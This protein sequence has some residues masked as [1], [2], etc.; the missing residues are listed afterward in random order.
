MMELS[1]ARERWK[2]SGTWPKVDPIWRALPC[3]MHTSNFRFICWAA[4]L[5]MCQNCWTN[6]RLGNCGISVGNND[7][8][9]QPREFHDEYI[10]QVWYKWPDSFIRTCGE[11]AIRLGSQK[12]GNLAESDLKS[13]SSMKGPINNSSII[14]EVNLLNSLSEDV[15]KLIDQSEAKKD[16]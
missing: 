1:E 12:I 9:I 16:R 8:L 10:D 13:Y 11:T 5:E 15:R 6:T 14:F 7:K 2:L 4:Y 3:V